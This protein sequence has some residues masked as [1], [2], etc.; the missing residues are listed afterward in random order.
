M[1]CIKVIFY[2]VRKGELDLESKHMCISIIAYPICLGKKNRVWR[3]L[4]KLSSLWVYLFKS[5]CV[6]LEVHI[7][8]FENCSFRTLFKR[9]SALFTSSFIGGFI[10]FN[11]KINSCLFQILSSLVSFFRDDHYYQQW[12]IVL[13][14]FLVFQ[15]MLSPT[16]SWVAT[17]VTILTA[18]KLHNPHK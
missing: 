12:Y 6:F 10:F 11:Y 3:I 9:A 17:N 15:N 1:D 8:Y 13:G 16:F 14:F 7:P 5:L 18:F 2:L 4:W